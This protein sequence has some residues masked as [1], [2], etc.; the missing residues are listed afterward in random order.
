GF[1]TKP[2]SNTSLG[3]S[4]SSFFFFFLERRLAEFEEGNVKVVLRIDLTDSIV[5]A[6]RPVPML[7]AKISEEEEE[8]EKIMRLPSQNSDHDS[9]VEANGN[10][11][12]NDNENND[13]LIA[14]TVIGLGHS[15]FSSSDNDDELL[16]LWSPQAQTEETRRRLKRDITTNNNGSLAFEHLSDTAKKAV[17]R[18]LQMRQQIK[19][20]SS[21]LGQQQHQQQTSGSSPHKLSPVLLNKSNANGKSDSNLFKHRL[22]SQSSNS[23]ANHANTTPEWMSALKRKVIENFSTTSSTVVRLPA[24]HNRHEPAQSQ[25]DSSSPIYQ[26]C[27]YSNFQSFYLFGSFLLYI[28]VHIHIYMYICICTNM[29]VGVNPK[30]KKTM[31]QHSSSSSFSRRSISHASSRSREESLMSMSDIEKYLGTDEHGNAKIVEELKLSQEQLQ[32]LQG[33]FQKKK[34]VI[35]YNVFKN[36]LI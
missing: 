33:L 12:N 2:E 24:E 11:G 6:T 10:G 20:S 7:R 23:Y 16:G 1:N 29:Y 32:K 8:E 5:P 31:R 18:K 26:V 19:S 4:N 36:W 35:F 17:S 30:K 15:R 28:F 13:Q 9:L 25:L 21:L 3:F 14:T 27:R 34:I 22:H